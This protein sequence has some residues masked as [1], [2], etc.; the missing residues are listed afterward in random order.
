MIVQENST[1]KAVKEGNVINIYLKGFKGDE[2]APDGS[3]LFNEEDLKKYPH[4][5]RDELLWT[6][7]LTHKD[8]LF[9]IFERLEEDNRCLAAEG[10]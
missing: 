4:W 1:H 9:A 2:K 6:I 8:D 7:P 3:N 5:F 10:I